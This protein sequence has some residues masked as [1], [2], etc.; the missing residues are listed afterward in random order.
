MCNIARISPLDV[1]LRIVGD[2]DREHFFCADDPPAPLIAVS[3]GLV[4]ASALLSGP[5]KGMK[6]KW[7]K[8]IFHTQE[9]QRSVGFVCTVAGV[10]ELHAQYA[11]SALQISTR[12]EFT[13]KPAGACK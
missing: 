1:G 2:S 10:S 12:P 13:K 3:C 7:I 5:P 8:V 11:M 6:Q 9:W 4:Q